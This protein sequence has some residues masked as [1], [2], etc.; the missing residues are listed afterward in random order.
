MDWTLFFTAV[1][2]VA[3]IISTIVAVRAKNEAKHILHQIKEEQSRNVTNS[4]HVEIT[5]SGTNS[6]IVSGINTGEMHV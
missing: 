3:T 5:N 1:G 4:G 6:G 2:A